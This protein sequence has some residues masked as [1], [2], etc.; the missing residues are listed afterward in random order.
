M[1]KYEND[2]VWGKNTQHTIMSDSY[3]LL[4]KEGRADGGLPTQEALPSIP[5]TNSHP[6]HKNTV[7][8]NIVHCIRA[9]ESSPS[10]LDNFSNFI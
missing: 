2:T 1:N 5:P 10:S 6:L 3:T 7:Q 4:K 9:E 8:R